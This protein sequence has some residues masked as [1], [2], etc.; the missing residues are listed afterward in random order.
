L[1]PLATIPIEPTSALLMPRPF[2]T[3]GLARLERTPIAVVSP[4]SVPSGC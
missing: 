4:A 1:T 3:L 2:D